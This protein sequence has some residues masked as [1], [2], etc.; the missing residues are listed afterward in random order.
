MAALF[1]AISASDLDRA[2]GTA[3][4][5][6]AEEDRRG[7]HTAAQ[8]LRGSLTPN[9]RNGGGGHGVLSSPV[10]QATLLSRGLTPLRQDVCL[11]DVVL[12]PR[13]HHE[14]QTVIKEWQNRSRLAKRGIRRRS[15]LLFYGPPGC[16]KS[17]AGRALGAELAIPA[18][19]VRFDAIIGAYLGQTAIHLREL[20][21]FAEG[22]PSVL[23]LDEVDAL[24][25]RRGNPL[26]VGELDRIVI[27]LM[28]ELE[29]CEVQGLVIATSNLPSHLDQ[30]LW[31]RF[32][33]AVEFPKPS[34]RELMSYARR[35][36]RD[37]H[38]GISSALRNRIARASSYAQ[39]ERLIE[40]QAR[41]NALR[42]L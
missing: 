25:K 16:G 12:R 15:K 31:R 6:A 36:A 33:L 38:V 19:V 41:H 29:H 23:L 18:Y 28:Q 3:A 30:A 9:G 24:G 26:D 13:W 22:T 8:A 17:L 10:D 42:N 5:I 34:R 37:R 40:D 2:R 21:R 4:Q 7:H 1:Q 27:S 20:F 11:A 39:A 32:D 35:V 14:L